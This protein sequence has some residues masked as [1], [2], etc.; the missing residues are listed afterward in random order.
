MASA[1]FATMALIATSED[2]S[3]PLVDVRNVKK[4]FLVRRGMFSRA[5]GYVRAVDGVSFTIRKGE[6]LGLV[7]ESGCGK[8]TLGRLMLHLLP[9]TE[10]E[11]YFEG[12]DVTRT[13]ARDLKRFR[14]RAQIVFQDPYSSLNPRMTVGSALREV[15]LVH[16]IVPKADAS[17]KVAALLRMVG[18]NDFHARRYPH[19]FSSGQRQRI[20]IARALAS[21]PAFLVCDEPVSALDVSI[22]AQIL[23]LL[24]DLREQLQ[25][26]YLF[27]SHDLTVVQHMSD[28]IAIM[29]LGRI[30][31][32]GPVDD[33]M[34]NPLHPYTQALLASAP[35][36]DPEAMRK[37]PPLGKELPN[38]LQR[39]SGCTFHTRCPVA[40]ADCRCTIPQLAVHEGERSVSCLR[41][42][43]SWPEG[44]A[45]A[46]IQ[47]FS[48]EEA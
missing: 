4:W 25:L 38:P 31:E 16:D 35:I 44:Q 23:N 48:T 28:R 15:L 39:P 14:Q 27:I 20:G 24:S 29:Y 43:C 5:L 26:T 33:V 17:E 22:Q 37:P 42:A 10:G 21:G 34:Q 41:Y 32:M 12:R 18:L 7:G 13:P 3:A 2:F 11:I 8:S 40:T 30:V 6:V 47:E 1:Y 19:E 46:L 36:A 45:P 9:A